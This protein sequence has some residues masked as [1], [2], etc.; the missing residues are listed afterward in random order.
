MICRFEI[1]EYMMN[2]EE[3]MKILKKIKK[4]T[5]ITKIIMI[6]WTISFIVALV[7]I[8]MYNTSSL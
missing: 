4:N 6:I 8:Y 5:D 3:I 2:E 1:E 7:V